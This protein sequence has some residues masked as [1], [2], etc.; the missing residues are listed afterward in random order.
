MSGNLSHF[1]LDFITCRQENPDQ[2]FQEY[3]QDVNIVCLP[4]YLDVVSTQKSVNI[5][6]M[7]IIIS[8]RLM[9]INM[10]NSIVLGT[11]MPG[12]KYNH[13]YKIDSDFEQ[14]T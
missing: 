2:Y 8:I 11:R 14:V 3:L 5:I 13:C 12:F 10:V 7:Y 4:E 1:E 9:M 6:N